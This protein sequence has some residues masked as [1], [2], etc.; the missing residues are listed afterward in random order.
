MSKIAD[1]VDPFKFEKIA[2]LVSSGSAPVDDFDGVGDFGAK[3]IPVLSAVAESGISA[4]AAFV[5]VVVDGWSGWCFHG[6]NAI[7][8]RLRG[9]GFFIAHLGFFL[10]Q[11]VGLLAFPFF[12]Y[13][14]SSKRLIKNPADPAKLPT[15]V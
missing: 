5:N 14:F 8:L 12:I 15:V 10:T 7:L 9:A 6:L 3:P 2:D 1:F 13:F 4:G 11:D